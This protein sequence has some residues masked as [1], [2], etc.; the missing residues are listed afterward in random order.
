VPVDTP[1]PLPPEVLPITGGTS[2]PLTGVAM[3]LAALVAGVS[4]LFFVRRRNH[5]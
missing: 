3:I 2:S 1:T 5:A 4:A